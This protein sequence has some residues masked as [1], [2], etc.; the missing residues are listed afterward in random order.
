[1]W[2]FIKATN[3]HL[4]AIPSS[5]KKSIPIEINA[6][7]SAAIDNFEFQ[8]AEMKSGGSTY[9]N[10]WSNVLVVPSY[11]DKKWLLKCMKSTSAFTIGSLPG[12]PL[13]FRQGVNGIFGNLID[14]KKDS[15]GRITSKNKPYL[16]YGSDLGRRTLDFQIGTKNISLS[17]MV[18][19]IIS[20][21]G[22]SFPSLQDNIDINLLKIII[23]RESRSYA[24]LCRVELWELDKNSFEWSTSILP[25]QTK[26][27]WLSDSKILDS[28][29]KTELISRLVNAEEDG[30]MDCVMGCALAI[31]S[32]LGNNLFYKN[33][34]SF[35][36]YLDIFCDYAGASHFSSSK[37]SSVATS[38][39]WSIDKE[40]YTRAAIATLLNT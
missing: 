13:Y 3:G 27:A 28:R 25:V 18:G 8:N 7:R 34:R 17:A 40:I 15:N 11:V 30:L 14:K 19:S 32:C 38:N 31:I 37:I 23:A 6:L 35:K 24:N 9:G 1:M 36:D 2:E 10:K 20:F 22:N 29:M 4:I 39:F 21:L 16:L 5:T 12:S 33:D 26:A